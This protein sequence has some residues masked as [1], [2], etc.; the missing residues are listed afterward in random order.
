MKHQI[1]LSGKNKKNISL[2]SVEFAYRMVKFKIPS[3]LKLTYNF[4]WP[5]FFMLKRQHH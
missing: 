5:N 3:N 4:I 2:L 1:L